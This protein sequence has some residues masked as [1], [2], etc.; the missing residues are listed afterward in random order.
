MKQIYLSYIR[1]FGVFFVIISHAFAPYGSW[2]WIENNENSFFGLTNKIIEPFVSMMPLLTFSSGFLFETIRYKYNSF[3]YLLKKKLE[4]LIV[5]MILI[6]TI[7]YFMFENTLGINITVINSIL[8]GYSILWYCNMLF[9][10]FIVAYPITKF[11][12]NWYIKIL[13]LFFFLVLIYI[14]VPAILGIN[15]LAKL[16]FYFYLG[17]IFSELIP[18]YKIL[19]FTNTY[20]LL[21]IIFVINYTLYEYYLIYNINNKLIKILS[22]NTLRIAFML[23]VIL[24]LKKNEQNFTYSPIVKFLD[25]NSFGCYIFHYPIVYF[26]YKTQLVALSTLFHYWFFPVCTVII[27]AILAYLVTYLLRKSKVGLY[28]FG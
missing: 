11:I 21:F 1:I 24:V 28:L 16:F 23:F 14:N 8:S 5:P 19:S 17:F 2:H 26:L 10:C 25:Q 27:A 15:Y 12:K 9:L 6:G 22:G 13:I 20:F 18:K 4:R 3:N 7:Y